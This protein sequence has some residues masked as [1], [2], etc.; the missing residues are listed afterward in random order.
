MPS[1]LWINSAELP[2]ITM[3]EAQEKRSGAF[4]YLLKQAQYHYL[5]AVVNE[6][7]GRSYS[8]S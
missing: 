2:R 4:V 6:V 5:A 3:P 1:L 8:S 7:K